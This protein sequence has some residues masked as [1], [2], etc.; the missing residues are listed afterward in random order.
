[1]NGRQY[2][3]T[4]RGSWPL[5][6]SDSRNVGCHLSACHRQTTWSPHL[7]YRRPILSFMMG[8]DSGFPLPSFTLADA[9]P[10]TFSGL[11]RWT[12]SVLIVHSTIMNSTSENKRVLKWDPIMALV[13]DEPIEFG[14][15]AVTFVHTLPSA[16]P[17]VRVATTVAL[18]CR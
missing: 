1:M 18:P 4:F 5:P 15:P 9:W 11:D 8:I 14:R 6:S 7:S 10:I 17:T 16:R 13:G 2:T 3:V 12:E